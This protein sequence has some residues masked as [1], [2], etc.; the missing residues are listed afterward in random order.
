MRAPCKVQVR[1]CE[2][3][4]EKQK[5]MVIMFFYKISTFL[6]RYRHTYRHRENPGRRTWRPQ[7]WWNKLDEE[8]ELISH[9]EGH[10]M[11]E[12]KCMSALT[13]AIINED[14][15][16]LQYNIQDRIMF[17]FFQNI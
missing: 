3:M 15:N 4:F 16:V 7:L 2:E 6:S 5:C 14:K 1:A 8:K 9:V 10:S 17:D 12:N 11:N 13:T